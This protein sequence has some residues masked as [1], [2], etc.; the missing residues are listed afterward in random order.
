MLYICMILSRH[1]FRSSHFGTRPLA[2]RAFLQP[3][4]DFQ[5][6]SFESRPPATVSCKP[7]AVIRFSVSAFN[8]EHSALNR[9]LVAPSNATLASFPAG[10][11]S[12][13]LTKIISLLD[14]TLTKNRGG[15]TSSSPSS[16][17][18][19]ARFVTRRNS[20]NSN[21]LMRLL[22]NLRTPRGGGYSS[23]RDSEFRVPIFASRFH[24]AVSC[25]RSAANSSPVSAFSYRLSSSG[26]F[27]V[28]PSNATLA[29]F[30]SGVDFKQLRQKLNPLDATLTKKPGGVS[31]LKFQPSFPA[32]HGTIFR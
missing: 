26:G 8:F 21:P 16:R 18:L 28:T 10:A 11:D 13:Q 4:T 12:K 14:A 24:V 6:S 17:R 22:H 23:L 25:E 19:L 20:R 27:L 7:S 15:A 30:S 2:P 31:P 1:P 5:V 3:Q 29:T 9:F 32:R